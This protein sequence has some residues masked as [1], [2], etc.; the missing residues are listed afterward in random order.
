VNV[1]SSS[2]QEQL[3]ARA[4]EV[5]LDVPSSVAGPLELY[6][7][8]LN[9][10]NARIN[11]TGLSLDRFPQKTL[12]R[13]ILE[14]LAAAQLLPSKPEEWFDL[15]SGSGSPAIPL[16]LV[17]PE[18]SLTM[19]EAKARKAAF[20]REAVHSLGLTGVDVLSGR[21]EDVVR[22]R[23]GHATLITV[24][25]VRLDLAMTAAIATLLK[26]EGRLLT[27]GASVKPDSPTFELVDSLRLRTSSDSASLWVRVS[28]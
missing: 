1:P 4:R 10:W 20:L 14:P 2:F 27:F 25:A 7:T 12:D 3:E 24:R 19:V 8:L 16:R 6:Y 11:L 15:G 26:I 23:S 17:R 21:V 18:F 13:L 9:R 28:N 22:G 5:G